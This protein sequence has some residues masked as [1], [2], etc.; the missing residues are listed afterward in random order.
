MG[1]TKWR[2]HLPDVQ[3]RITLAPLFPSRR[4]GDEW[5]IEKKGGSRPR[6]KASVGAVPNQPPSTGWKFYNY[7]TK[8]YEA[9]ELISCR[10][11]VSS[12]PCCLTISLSGAAKE[13]RAKKCEGEYKSTGLVSAGKLVMIN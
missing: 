1:D 11:F 9:D 6:L 5:L 7:D 13:S 8:E 4:S 2:V 12:P 3:V 10:D